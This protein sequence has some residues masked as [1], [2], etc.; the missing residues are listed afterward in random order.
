[1]PIPQENQENFSPP[2]EKCVEHNLK[3][4]DIVQKICALLGKLFAS[5]GVP[6]WLRTW[7]CHKWG[8]QCPFVF[9]TNY[10]ICPKS[11]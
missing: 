1:M 3:I 4:L 7:L 6:S 11:R 10:R 2:P 9:D 8:M 5:P